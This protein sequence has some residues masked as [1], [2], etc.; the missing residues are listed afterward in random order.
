MVKLNLVGVDEESAMGFLVDVV[1]ASLPIELSSMERK[2]L[3]GFLLLPYERYRHQR[4]SSHAR[5]KVFKYLKEKYGWNFKYP[6]LNQKISTLVKKGIL[7]RD[8]E[9]QVHLVRSLENLFGK[10]LKQ[11]SKE[12]VFRIVVDLP[13]FRGDFIEKEDSSNIIN[14][15][16]KKDD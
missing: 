13:K 6:N 1:C 11:S 5:K 14:L 15:Y 9:H 4:F 3:T 8:E 10:Y 2:M 7:Y 12:E 16:M